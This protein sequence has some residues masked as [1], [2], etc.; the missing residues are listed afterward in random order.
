MT[1][2]SAR[3]YPPYERLVMADLLEPWPHIT[4]TLSYMRW[5]LG[6]IRRLAG[7]ERAYCAH[8]FVRC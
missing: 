1:L 3:T 8:C 6:S 5:R 4:G 7:R 2:G